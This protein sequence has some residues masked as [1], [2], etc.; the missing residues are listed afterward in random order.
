MVST[1]V[2]TADFGVGERGAKKEGRQTWGLLPALLPCGW[3]FRWPGG[4]ESAE[5]AVMGTPEWLSD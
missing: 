3:G 2:A 1:V 5:F 4:G